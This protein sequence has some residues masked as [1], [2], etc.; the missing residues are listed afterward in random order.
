[1]QSPLKMNHS[2]KSTREEGKGSSLDLSTS[3]LIN[4]YNFRL[5]ITPAK[6]KDLLALISDGVIPS[7]Y[8]SFY[9]SLPVV[10]NTCE[11]LPDRDIL[12]PDTDEDDCNKEST[13]DDLTSLFHGSR[14]ACQKT[15]TA[16]KR[17]K[18][19]PKTTTRSNQ[20]ETITT[21]SKSQPEIE[22]TKRPKQQP[23]T[24]PDPNNNR[25]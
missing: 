3:T 5:T 15:E 6:E 1:M 20:Q 23:E 2:R 21:R 11:Y 25:Q 4:L 14:T 18:Q 17:S 10:R 12:D 7:A 24:Q 16:A 9:K 22:T 13:Q 8:R 19:Q